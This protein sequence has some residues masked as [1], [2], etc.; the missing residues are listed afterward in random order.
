MFTPSPERFPCYSDEL[1]RAHYSKVDREPQWGVLP[2]IEQ[3][4]DLHYPTELTPSPE[5]S[6][7]YFCNLPTK[8]HVSSDSEPAP[9]TGVLGGTHCPTEVDGI[10]SWAWFDLEIQR[11]LNTDNDLG[12]R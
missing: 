6:S 1:T 12:D 10:D 5:P 4:D 8:T 2:D 3:L 11:L 9:Q 7:F